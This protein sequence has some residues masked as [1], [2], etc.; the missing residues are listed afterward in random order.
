MLKKFFSAEIVLLWAIPIVWLPYII[1][2]KLGFDSDEAIPFLM[3]RSILAGE[4]PIFFWGNTYMGA[5]EAY[6]GAGLLWLFGNCRV[7]LV[8]LVPLFGYVFAAALFVREAPPQE[9]SARA[10]LICFAPPAL[11]NV[12][13][14]PGYSQGSFLWVAWVGLALLRPGLAKHPMSKKAF[15]VAAIAGVVA[16]AGQFYI[17][18][19]VLAVG[20][21]LL[22]IGCQVVFRDMRQGRRELRVFGMARTAQV[23]LVACLS[24]LARIVANWNSRRGVRVNLMPRSPMAAFK[25]LPL[26]GVAFAQ[27]CPVTKFGSG[28]TGLGAFFAGTGP[29]EREPSLVGLPSIT[30]LAIFVTAGQLLLTLVGAAGMGANFFRTTETSGA[31]NAA[32][33]FWPWLVVICPIAFLFYR[34]A[35]STGDARYLTPFFFPAVACAAH[36]L[37]RTRRRNAVLLAV[38]WIILVAVGHVR[39]FQM[40]H[41]SNRDIDRV[42]A[43]LE[44]QTLSRG[45]ADYW[46]GYT[47]VART[48][49]KLV[50]YPTRSSRYKPYEPIVRREERVFGLSF[51]EQ[52]PTWLRKR[53]KKYFGEPKDTIEYGTIRIDLFERTP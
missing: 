6:L 18:T 11:Y 50:I 22:A 44:G 30:P 1:H 43:Y 34:G 17:S 9:R 20:A 46:L 27:F 51:T 13:T 37:A 12:I 7:W 16:L 3:A 53:A 29:N 24:Q 31:Q 21:L 40:E 8:H 23:V 38:V 39:N 10:F 5:I 45:I 42:A 52:S 2:W 47:M 14:R 15:G 36:A 48:C 26:L 49:E 25:K 4:R 35:N 28:I 41:D 33:L 19:T 32:I